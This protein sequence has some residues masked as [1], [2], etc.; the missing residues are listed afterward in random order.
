MAIA[1][2]PLFHVSVRSPTFTVA[3]SNTARHPSSCDSGECLRKGSG[4]NSNRISTMKTTRYSDDSPSIECSSIVSTDF[5]TLLIAT[6]WSTTYVDDLFYLNDEKMKSPAAI[7]LLI[8][9]RDFE[10]FSIT[11]V[12]SCNM[13]NKRFWNAGFTEDTFV[14]KAP[15]HECFKYG[16]TFGV[17][18][19]SGSG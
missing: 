16:L 1:P 19:E 6:L 11:S 14:T 13:S 15:T 3:L 8:S 2:I 4:L 18:Y 9:L 5:C 17:H 7:S 10:I 12:F